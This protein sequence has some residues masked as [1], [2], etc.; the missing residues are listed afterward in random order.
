MVSMM[1]DEPAMNLS[2]HT[3]Y[4]SCDLGIVLELTLISY[5]I[6]VGITCG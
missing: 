5:D 3:A 6:Q 1:I 4:F 2:M